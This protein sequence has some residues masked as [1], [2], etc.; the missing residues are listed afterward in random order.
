MIRLLK[1]IA[2]PIRTLAYRLYD[3]FGY[4]LCGLLRFL[5]IV[6]KTPTFDKSSV[7]KILIIRLDR[8][9]DVILSTPAIRA[10]RGNFPNAQIHL[11]VRD[12]TKDLVANNPNI[13][14]I[15]VAHRDGIARD[16]DLAIALHPGITQ[17]RIAWQSGAR[18]RLGYSG[19]GGGFFLTHRITDD[20]ATRVRHEVESALEI[21]AAV[22][23]MIQDKHPEISITEKGEAAAREFMRL[24]G[25]KESDKI[26]A[27]HPGSR[28]AYLR[29]SKEGFAQVADS[30]IKNA[31][32]K[33]ILIGSR[34]EAP[35]AQEVISFMKE[36]PVAALGLE[37]TGLVSLMKRCSLF[38]GN[39]TGTM[40]IA[41]ALGV[42]VVAIFGNIH[43]LDSYQ[44]WG[45]WGEKHIVVSKNLNCAGCHPGDCKTFDCM[46]LIS[47]DDVLKAAHTLL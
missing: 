28:Q 27:I 21:V 44:E 22:G 30:L 47:S 24:N 7:K 46:R 29:W 43:P 6:P 14:K 33:V 31:G 26:I 2:R 36:K 12:Y 8:I 34:Q 11:L 1:Q 17:N 42:P 41:A 40:H 25:L 10:V 38:I 13:N 45:P 23:C 3:G 15:L 4:G 32:A 16:Y 9:G 39:S 19:A 20:R 37:L 5:R 35:L 18:Y